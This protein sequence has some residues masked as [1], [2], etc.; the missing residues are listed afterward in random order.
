V[1]DPIWRRDA[2]ELADL[3]RA[4]ELSAKEILEAF[5]ERIELHNEELN[6]LVH[7]DPDRARAEAAEIDRRIASGEDPGPLAGVPL[8]VKDLENVAGMPTRLGS[9]LYKDNVADHDGA[10]TARLRAAGAV[11]VGKTA[12]PEFGSTANTRTILHG[13]T[14]NPWNLERTPGGSS[15][16]SAAA[17]A[18]AILPIGTA[19]DGGGSIRIPASYSG[20]V[21]AKGTFG[22]IPKVDG[23]ESSFTSVLGCVSRTVRDTARYWDCVVGHDERDPYSLPHPGLSY[24]AVLSQTPTRLRVAWSDDL[25]FGTCRRDV[26]AIARTAADALV[27]VTDS[28]WTDARIE[29]KDMSV[30]WG[31]FNHPGTWLSVRDFWPQRSEDFT[32]AVRAGVHDGERRFTMPEYAR[33]I[34]RRYEN[35]LRLARLFENVDILLTPTTA[36]TAFRAEGPMPTEIGGR[37]IRPMHAI[38]FTYPF[39]ISGHPA[40]SVPCGF[41]ADGLPVA[42]QIVAPRHQDHVAMQLAAAFEQARPWTKIATAYD[43]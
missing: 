15:G 6:A 23:A 27:D 39:N 18:A 2:Y 37:E 1:A 25:G 35:N 34:E 36:T 14:R 11:V 9:V 12:T 19:S 26:A 29:L 16:G 4:Q 30:A 42:L 40:V 13:T 10:Q 33:A 41:D 32:P 28:M 21:G 24:E 8:G 43:A 31:L 5:L 38:T 7:L 17:V 22:R 3:V 20:L